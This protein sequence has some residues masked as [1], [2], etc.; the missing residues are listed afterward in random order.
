MQITSAD[1]LIEPL[2]QSL[3]KLLRWAE[4]YEPRMLSERRAYD[5]DL[6]EAEDLLQAVQAWTLLN[7]GGVER[8]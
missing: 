5:A 2:G 6:D 7:G 3:R 4:A 1:D 8:R